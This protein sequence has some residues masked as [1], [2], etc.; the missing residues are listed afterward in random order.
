MFKDRLDAAT[1][2]A[3]HLQAYKGKKPLVL[4]IPRGAVPMALHIANA[5][6]G[7][8]DVV[9]V[10]KLRAPH[11]PE[12]AIGAV[13]ES[14]HF[15][16]APYA[17]DYGA[18]SDYIDTEKQTQLHTIAERRKTYSALHARIS[19]AGR[20]TIVVDDGMATGAS[21]VAAL[22]SVRLTQ[23]HKLVCAVPVASPEALA[24]VQ[25]LADEVVCLQAPQY[26]QAVGQFY[27]HFPQVE[28]EEIAKMFA[29]TQI[30][31][32]YKAEIE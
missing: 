32:N 15:Q 8:M 29:D 26:F 4:A 11:Q 31:Q 14:G 6:G 10:R 2:L 1:Q 20:I 19:P 28:D 22:K 12:L 7:E 25:A 3:Q 24:K 5:L 16:L 23:P 30:H 13:D 9:L 17:Q 21:M 27:T 18:T